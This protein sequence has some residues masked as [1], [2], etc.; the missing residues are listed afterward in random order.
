MVT[1]MQAQAAMEDHARMQAWPRLHAGSRFERLSYAC[2]LA[3]PPLPALPC[4]D[5]R[6]LPQT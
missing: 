6:S 2:T 4:T 3:R 5:E 1:H